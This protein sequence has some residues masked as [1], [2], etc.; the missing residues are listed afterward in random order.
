MC[1]DE[2]HA[3]GDTHY[4]EGEILYL[5]FGSLVGKMQELLGSK[6]PG[7]QTMFPSLSHEQIMASDIIS[8][9]T[10]HTAALTKVVLSTEH[11]WK[12]T[13]S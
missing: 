11:L 1:Q 13:Q 9:F 2:S 8:P 10:D 3:R 12:P 6:K 4:K 5:L 7:R